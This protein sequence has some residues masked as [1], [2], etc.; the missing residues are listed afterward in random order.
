MEL[1][2]NHQAGTKWE[3]LGITEKEYNVIVEA[4][5]KIVKVLYETPRFSDRTELIYKAI[6]DSSPEQS[7]IMF[8]LFIGFLMRQHHDLIN[9]KQSLMKMGIVVATNAEEFLQTIEVGGDIQ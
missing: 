1:K 8:S 4:A 3:A 6:K 7:T 2:F 9:L 5:D